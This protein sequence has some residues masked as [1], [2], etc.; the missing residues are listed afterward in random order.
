MSAGDPRAR[1]YVIVYLKQGSHVGSSPWRG[2]LEA[3]KR[4]AREGLVRRGADECQIR[5]GTL[6]GPLIWR[7]HKDA[8]AM[9]R[10][11]FKH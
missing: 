1:D 3:A 5:T 11:P 4:V 9:S 6:D 7:E 2:E 8:S 10:G